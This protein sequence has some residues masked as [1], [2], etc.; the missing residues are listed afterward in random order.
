MCGISIFHRG[1]SHS[2]LVIA[3]L[4]CLLTTGCSGQKYSLPSFN[5][6]AWNTSKQ[7]PRKETAPVEQNAGFAHVALNDSADLDS[8]LELTGSGVIPASGQSSRGEQA[9][10][11]SDLATAHEFNDID[12]AFLAEPAPRGGSTDSQNSPAIE[13]LN[14]YERVV[15]TVDQG[16]SH[17][18]ALKNSLNELNATQETRNPDDFTEFFQVAKQVEHASPPADNQIARANTATETLPETASP[19][20]EFP[21]ASGTARNSANAPSTN[22]ESALERTRQLLASSRALIQQNNYNAART[23]AESAQALLQKTQAALLPGE[24]TPEQVLADI[25]ARQL[26]NEQQLTNSQDAEL[27]SSP[28]DAAVQ[29][30][31]HPPA[32]MIDLNREWLNTRKHQQETTESELEQF[33]QATVLS[34][35]PATLPVINPAPM[36]TL[37]HNGPAISQESANRPLTLQPESDALPRETEVVL[38]GEMPAQVES[39]GSPF[40]LSGVNP[41]RNETDEHP[42]A[43]PLLIAPNGLDSPSA[44]YD[45][46]AADFANVSQET[47]PGLEEV[48]L[49]IDESEL[50]MQPKQEPFLSSNSLTLILCGLVVGVVLFLRWRR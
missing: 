50:Q 11:E 42:P 28:S 10:A 18:S 25:K 9:I 37:N 31:A 5:W 41:M 38:L 30:V 13:S 1:Y 44:E 4:A 14:Q 36:G 16:E 23:V 26:Q 45:E 49:L 7:S 43:P 47:P 32:V 40:V 39:S 15:S 22:S 6:T 27:S 21:W 12:Q 34:N 3:T 48:A 29:T 2:G 8:D 24:V 33:A 35:Q 20:T 19:A 17:L 46:F